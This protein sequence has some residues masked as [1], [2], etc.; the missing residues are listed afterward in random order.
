MSSVAAGGSGGSGI[1]I[2]GHIPSIYDLLETVNDQHER[3]IS[4][5]L[6]VKFLQEIIM[7]ASITSPE[8]I[9]QEITSARVV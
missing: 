8:V 5:S 4:L 3:I 2:D 1:P 7:R 9:F 6:Q